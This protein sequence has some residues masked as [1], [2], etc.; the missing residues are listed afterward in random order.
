MMRWLLALLLLANAGMF[1]WGSWYKDADA[2]LQPSPQADFNAGQMRLISDPAVKLTPLVGS[3]APVTKTLQPVERVCY[4]VGEFSSTK[5]A[6]GAGAQLKKTGLEY[7]LRTEET[8]ERSYQVY[9]PPLKSLASAAAMQSRLNKLGFR[10]NALMQQ[11]GFKNGVSVGIFKVKAN[12]NQMQRD[13]KRNGI[14]SK[15][16]TLTKSR[17]RFWLDV[18]ADAEKLVALKGIRWKSKTVAVKQT[19]CTN[20]PGA[21]GKTK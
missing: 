10:D 3:Q 19:T 16:R 20:A 9:I 15:Q 12:A 13:L 8:V 1:M 14:V 18:P 4:E 6:M 5:A 17:S 11:K 2:P 21:N 7:S